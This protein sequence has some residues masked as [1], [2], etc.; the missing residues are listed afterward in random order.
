MVDPVTRTFT[1]KVDI[2]GSD[3]RS[4]MYGRASFPVG[5]KDGLYV[6]KRA[7]VER[8]ALTSLWVAGKDNIARMRLVKTGKTVGDKVEVLAGLTGG[9]RIVTGGVE[10]VV[11]R[12]ENR[13]KQCR[14]S[15]AT[16]L[17]LL[18][19]GRCT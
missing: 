18:N 19:G 15:V 4:G 17:I 3:L 2:T 16:L 9:E 6:P 12:G 8:G 1:I 14:L 10:K 5:R 11:R 13:M 7:L